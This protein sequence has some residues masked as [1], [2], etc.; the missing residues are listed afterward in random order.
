MASASL[1]DD[2]IATIVEKIPTDRVRERAIG[3]NILSS[4][5]RNKFT[6]EQREEATRARIIQK[7]TKTWLKLFE[8]LETTDFSPYRVY[9]KMETINGTSIIITTET[10]SPETLKIVVRDQQIMEELNILRGRNVP[11]SMYGKVYAAYNNEGPV[12]G[13]HYPQYVQRSNYAITHIVDILMKF[14]DPAHILELH[15]Y[16][17]VADIAIFTPVTN[18]GI[19]KILDSLHSIAIAEMSLGTVAGGKSKPKNKNKNTNPK[20][21]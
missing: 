9:I 5:V 2:V 18:K 15:S 1:P 13:P 16:E 20:K 4:G 10:H 12:A 8:L 7:W 17:Q 6:P 11:Y 19:Q 3:M 21:K 14:Q